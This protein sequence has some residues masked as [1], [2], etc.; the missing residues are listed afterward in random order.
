MLTAAPDGTLPQVPGWQI[1]APWT[2][3]DMIKTMVLGPDARDG[4][5]Q[6]S[7]FP[8][9][10]ASKAISQFNANES[11]FDGAADPGDAR[12]NNTTIVDFFIILPIKV[13]TSGVRGPPRRSRRAELPQRA[14]Q[15]YAQV[16]SRSSLELVGQT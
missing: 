10:F 6:E 13:G 12:A 5:V 9:P 8:F 11:S 4:T 2:S 7:L 14:P 1:G 15:E 3:S 16:E